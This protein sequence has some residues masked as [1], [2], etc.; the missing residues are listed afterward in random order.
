[1][2]KYITSQN[3]KYGVPIVYLKYINNSPTI[4]IGTNNYIIPPIDQ[5]KEVTEDEWPFNI[6]GGGG[7][8]K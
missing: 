2:Y 3:P 4:K 8:P 5:I 1:M 6:F 7:G